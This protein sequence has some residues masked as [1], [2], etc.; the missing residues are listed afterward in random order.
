MQQLPVITEQFISNV[1][2]NSQIQKGKLLVQAGYVTE[3][4]IKHDYTTVSVSAKCKAT[5]K[6]ITYQVELKFT[7]EDIDKARCTCHAGYV[8]FVQAC[9]CVGAFVW[10]YKSL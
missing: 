7:D 1:I 5:M 10:G 8:M 4:M 3:V 9:V 6:K 2:K